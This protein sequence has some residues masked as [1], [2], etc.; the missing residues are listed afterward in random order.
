MTARI[1]ATSEDTLRSAALAVSTAVGE[2][3]FR[4]LVTAI[5]T[6][7]QAELAFI[8]LPKAPG[9]TRMRMLAYYALGRIVEDF[10]Y[11]IAGTP[12]ETVIGQEVRVYPSRLQELFPKDTDFKRMK[13]QSYAGC[14]LTDVRGQPVGLMSVVLGREMEQPEL[15]ESVLKIFAARAEAEIEHRS[16]ERAIREREAQYRATFDAS[17]DG[18]VVMNAEGRIVD[19]NPA[20][21]AMFGRARDELLAMPPQSLVPVESLEVC[22]RVLS[23]AGDG[24]V[25]QGE[26]RARRADGALFDIELRGVPMHYLGRPHKLIIVRDVTERKRAEEAVR[27]SEEQYRAIFNASEDALVLWDSRLRRV[28]VNPAYERMFGLTRDEV[29][30]RGQDVRPLSPEYAERRYDLV[31]RTLAGEACRAELESMRGSGERFLIEVRTIPV[32]HRG[33][34]HVLATVRDITER[35]RRE[36][37]LRASEE[38]YR[39]IFNATSDALVL[40]DAG[41]RIV[42]VNAAYEAMG[43]RRRDEV[44]GLTDLT[45]TRGAAVAG[46]RRALHKEAIE[47][48]PVFFEADGT[49]PDGTPFVLEVRGIPMTYRGEPHVLYIGRDI[50]ARKAAEEALRASEEQYRAI[51]NASFDGMVIRTLEGEIVDV[52]PALLAMYGYER[53]DL[54]GKTFGP[55]ISGKRIEGFREY[56]AEVAAGRPYRTESRVPRK[57]GSAVYIEVLGSPVTYRGKPHVLSVVRDIT[58]RRAGEVRLRATVEG[59]LDCIIV[60]DSEG[61]IRE[62][63]AA[64]EACFGYRRADVLGKSLAD[65]LIPERFRDAHQRGMA[66]Y[67]ESGEGPFLGKRVEVTGRRADGTEFPAELAI[68]VAQEPGGKFFVGYL[69]DLTERRRADSERA[70]LEGQLRQAQKM[71][72]IGNLTGGI[73]HDFNN[74]LTGILGYLRLASE[75]Q[76]SLGDPKLERYLGQAE[77]ASRRARDLIQQMLTFSRRGKGTP[78]PVEIAGLIEESVRLLGSSLPSTVEIA[79]DMQSALPAV[80]IDPVQV[81][82][83]LL[84]LCINARDA[85]SGIGTIRVGVRLGKTAGVV[86]ASCR[87]R[88][89]GRF[90]ELSV[91]DTGSGIAPEVLERMFEPFYST[92]EV[93][94]GSG[95]GLAMVHGIVHEHGGHIGVDTSREG[96][97][98]RVFL[99][100]IADAAATERNA[101]GAGTPATQRAGLAGHILV[102]DDE[103]IVGEFMSELLQNWGLTVTVQPSGPEALAWFERHGDKVDAVVTD[104]TMPR[105]TGIELARRLTERRSSLPVLLYSGYAE[106]IDKAQLERAGVRALLRKPVEPE[107]LRGRLEAALARKPVEAPP[108]RKAPRAA[109]KKPG[110]GK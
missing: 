28:D 95:M 50:T 88:I 91:A 42:D 73:A 26:C 79:T 10:E 11:D 59:A 55:I 9:G 74:I 21:L 71:E 17:V 84:N 29:V 77:Q 15:V 40:R 96:T 93:G 78:R 101:P 44:I 60:M 106:N 75:R 33:E 56:L 105:M 32:Q 90:V 69:R 30:G 20:F 1:P 57:D 64:A 45:L 51:F 76:V 18:M 92:K 109:K 89:E 53:D 98:F 67:L 52:N 70:R 65:T 3:V 5:A 103:Q 46:E 72:A 23:A 104:Q 83:V 12:C 34:P 85:M 49:W 63:N 81:E 14:P 80:M 25:F 27:A 7:L 94:R 35:K 31:R 4:E 41:F 13:L 87:K 47:G 19:A 6:I 110:R 2:N 22:S 108:P 61:L 86:C 99:P 36:E 48:K 37:A 54:I 100:P 24:K 8:A 68:G 38:Q 43:G 102:V 107:A 82:Q 16:A 97:K 66:R 58:E 39:A 62:F